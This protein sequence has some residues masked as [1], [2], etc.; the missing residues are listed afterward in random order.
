MAAPH[1]RDG[2]HLSSAELA[3]GAGLLLV[4]MLASVA[5]NNAWHLFTRPF[6][7]DEYHTVF[8][9]RE[10]S[11]VALLRDLARGADFNPPLL[12][13]VLHAVRLL[14]GDVT[15]VAVRLI[16]FVTAWLTAVLV[17]AVV[18]PRRGRLVT[19]HE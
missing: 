7:I 12:H 6:W 8:L 3:L 1:G 10:S 16:T 13:L 9:A 4:A 17:Y 18:Q 19:L 15:P 2:V 11:S 14:T 5:V